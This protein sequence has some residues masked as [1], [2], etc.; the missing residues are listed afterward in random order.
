M[1]EYYRSLAEL[2]V[3]SKIG[4]LVKSLEVT[5]HGPTENQTPLFFVEIGSDEEQWR[6]PSLGELTAE[7]LYEKSTRNLRKL[8]LLLDLEEDIMHQPFHTI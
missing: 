8:T 7:A 5:H 3:T 2:D 4:N 6:N 1:S